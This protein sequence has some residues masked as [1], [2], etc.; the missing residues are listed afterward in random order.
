MRTINNSIFERPS[1]LRRNVGRTAWTSR[2]A[3]WPRLPCSL[4]R[5]IPRFQPT[6]MMSADVRPTPREQ[7]VNHWCKK[8]ANVRSLR[9]LEYRA[10][11]RVAA[12]DSPPSRLQAA[13]RKRRA[14]SSRFPRF[15]SRHISLTSPRCRV[16]RLRC[17]EVSTCFRSRRQPQAI[18]T[19]RTGGRTLWISG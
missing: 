19:P 3:V 10:P 5:L 12:R 11:N 17:R 8:R 14:A 6:V 1:D 15:K 9:N 7:A 18:A 2:G 4:L 13:P 16:R